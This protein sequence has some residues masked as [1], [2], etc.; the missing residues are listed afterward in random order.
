M[1]LPFV[2]VSG[3]F[4]RF[5]S[6]FA[7]EETNGTN[8]LCRRIFFPHTHTKDG[9]KQDIH[10]LPSVEAM[11]GRFVAGIGVGYAMMIALVYSGGI[12]PRSIR[13]LITSFT[14]AFINLG[15]LLEHVSNYSFPKPAA[16]LV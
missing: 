8:M 5:I 14:E 1:A 4:V 11:V 13:G 2:E 9:K 15:E 10:H 7:T 16:N 6:G 12:S 3:P